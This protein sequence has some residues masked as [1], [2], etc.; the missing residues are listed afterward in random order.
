[1]EPK[2]ADCSLRCVLLCPSTFP[3]TDSRR[4]RGLF[5]AALASRVF[6]CGVGWAGWLWHP[7]TLP[8]LVAKICWLAAAVWVKG[9]SG[10]GTVKNQ[11][12]VKLIV[13]L[14]RLWTDLTLAC[15]PL[16]KPQCS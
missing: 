12:M 15:F 2:S 5:K 1:M 7:G 4:G 14:P 13:V 9:W 8:A 6:V 3:Q 11:G 16:I 10:F